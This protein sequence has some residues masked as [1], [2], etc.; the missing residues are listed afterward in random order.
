LLTVVA[1]PSWPTSLR[2]QATTVPSCSSASVCASPLAIALTPE[3]PDTGAGDV[4]FVVE[5]SPS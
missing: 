2:P 4:R 5:P 1:S 3:S